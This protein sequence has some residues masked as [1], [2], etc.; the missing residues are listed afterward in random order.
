MIMPTRPLRVL[1]V[2]DNKTFLEILARFLQENHGGEFVVVGTAGGS[3]E[4][5]AQAN[6]LQP[7]VIL[8]DF[9]LPEGQRSMLIRDL[10]SVLPQVGI[11]AMTLQAPGVY[12]YCRQV[13]LA[14]GADDL[15]LKNV[16][17]TELLPRIQRA[18][19]ARQPPGDVP[20]T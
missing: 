18:V 2:D 10:R 3:A 15:I 13:A 12:D 20:V 4:A 5:L 7:Q 1:L 16:L 17:T 14:D 8:L 9:D 19:Q 6:A 11:V